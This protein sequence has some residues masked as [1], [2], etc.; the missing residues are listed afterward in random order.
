MGDD[1]STLTTSTDMIIKAI[2]LNAVGNFCLVYRH[3][4]QLRRL[5]EILHFIFKNNVTRTSYTSFHPN[6]YEFVYKNEITG[7]S[8]TCVLTLF[9][10]S[11]TV[12]KPQLLV[13]H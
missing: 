12:M 13:N 5:A 2:N 1:N 11:M 6:K 10:M 7:R 3:K 4:V 9:K 8:I